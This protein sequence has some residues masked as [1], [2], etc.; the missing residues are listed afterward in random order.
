MNLKMNKKDNQ[1]L[2]TEHKIL[3]YCGLNELNYI[4]KIIFYERTL[5][6]NFFSYSRS[7]IH[8]TLGVLAPKKLLA[9]DFEPLS[10]PFPSISIPCK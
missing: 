9:S 3:T 2:F 10:S 8:D 7:K 1:F 4:L 6:V 5:K